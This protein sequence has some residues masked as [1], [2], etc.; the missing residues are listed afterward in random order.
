MSTFVS[1][2]IPGH[3]Y[4]TKLLLPTLLSTARLS[5]EGAVRVI[6][7]AS[8]GHT[9]VDKIDFNTLKD[10]PARRKMT[11]TN[12]YGQSKLVCLRAPLLSIS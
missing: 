9:I 3:F 11:P 4:L 8:S 1:N 7:T 6:N 12:L 2:A 5:P 10:G